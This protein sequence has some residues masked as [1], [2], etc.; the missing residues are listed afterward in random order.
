MSALYNLRGDDRNIELLAIWLNSEFRKIPNGHVL[1]RNKVREAAKEAFDMY[2]EMD[3]ISDN[4]NDIINDPRDILA[5]FA[6]ALDHAERR[7]KEEE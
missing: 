2:G 1:L 6:A 5:R 4:P 7:M 3:E